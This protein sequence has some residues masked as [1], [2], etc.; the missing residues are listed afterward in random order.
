MTSDLA[1]PLWWAWIGLGVIGL[2]LV[3]GG[4][5]GGQRRA[6]FGMLG[7]LIGCFLVLVPIVPRAGETD[8][9][10]IG[11]LVGAFALF[12]MMARFENPG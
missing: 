9:L 8:W 4:L 7:V 2:G 12:R 5:S 3:V 1:A 10:S 6:S 11:V